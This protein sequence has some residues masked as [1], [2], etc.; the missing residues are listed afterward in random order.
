MMAWRPS[1]APFVEY[2]QHDPQLPWFLMGVTTFLVLQSTDL[3]GVILLSKSLTLS[4]GFGVGLGFGFGLGSG[5]G[6]GVGVGV[7]VGVGL[8]VGVVVV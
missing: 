3:A 7:G 5:V 8:T 6:S 2:V 4:V 1:R